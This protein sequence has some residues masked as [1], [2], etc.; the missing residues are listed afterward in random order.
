MHAISCNPVSITFICYRIRLACTG[1]KSAQIE[2]QIQINVTTSRWPA[3]KTSLNFRRNKICLQGLGSTVQDVFE[4][5]SLEST[6]AG[7]FYI[8]IVSAIVMIGLILTTAST[9][10]IKKNK[11]IRSTQE[12]QCVHQQF[13]INVPIN[14]ILYVVT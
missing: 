10:C 2:V 4:P 8:G 13:S 5:E 7:S 1:Q 12:P 11:K 6:T 14:L 9:I 3:N